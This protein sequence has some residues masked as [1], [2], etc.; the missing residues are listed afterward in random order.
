MEKIPNIKAFRD[1][2][3]DPETKFEN[4]VEDCLNG[5]LFAYKHKW[6]DLKNFNIIDYERNSLRGWGDYNEIIP[7][8]II[9][10]S[11][12]LNESKINK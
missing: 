2:T 5:L 3:L 11:G 7:G 10:F 6:F 1:S 12:P 4:T 8:K 9:A